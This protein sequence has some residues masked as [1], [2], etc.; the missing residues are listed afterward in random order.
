MTT[1]GAYPIKEEEGPL[2]LFKK[3]QKVW[4]HLTPE[5]ERELAQILERYDIHPLTIEDIFSPTNRI[6]VERFPHYIYFSFRGFH[7]QDGRLIIKA[8]NFLFFRKTLITITPERRNTI[9]DLI[10][11][12][13]EH[14]VLLQRGPEFI[15]HRILDVETDRTLAIVH[16]LDEMVDVYEIELLEF[17][18]NVDIR[19]VFEIR[20]A[21]QHIRKVMIL[22]KEVLDDL[23]LRLPQF[24][25][26][27]AAAF[28]RDVRDHSLKIIDMV[29]SITNSI[30]SALEA[31]LT[32]ST[33]RTND[34]MRILTIL[35]ALM[36]PMTLIT[37]I[38]GM[39]FEKMPF[40]A[41]DFGFWGTLIFMG[42]I[43]VGMTLY[44]KYKKWL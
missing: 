13:Q 26:G 41:H 27:E 31:Y 17:V 33:R 37:G 3:N 40:L 35:T 16:R 29:D 44:F 5:N 8:F 30:S 18:L 22:H 32:I 9:F 10:E 25:R 19:R 1:R 6:K 21:L 20:S 38:Y 23:Q 36:L 28:F 14:R 42:L 43:G 7:L 15:V 39:N 12:W 4:I 34:I 11:S 24:F 2:R